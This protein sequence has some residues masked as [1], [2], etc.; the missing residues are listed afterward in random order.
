MPI[1]VAG[2][3][4]AVHSALS[5]IAKVC[6]LH[7]HKTEQVEWRLFIVPSP[8]GTHGSCMVHPSGHGEPLPSFA[9]PKGIATSGSGASTPKGGRHA[10]QRRSLVGGAS[11]A[12]SPSSGSLGAQAARALG[13]NSVH[14]GSREWRLHRAIQVPCTLAQWLA[15]TDPWYCREVYS[16]FAHDS[17]TVPRL[18]RQIISGPSFS[19]RH[20]GAKATAPHGRQSRVVIKH[21]FEKNGE[22]TGAMPD[23]DGADDDDQHG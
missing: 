10:S 6:S 17:S 23:V 13:K 15:V 11:S 19:G 9:S 3:D 20:G 16:V 4:I 2:N 18:P 7:K 5:A 21:A 8:Q 14:V 22:G 12:S 1:V